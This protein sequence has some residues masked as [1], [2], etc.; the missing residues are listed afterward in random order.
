MK[1]RFKRIISLALS[2]S[3]MIGLCMPTYAA[4]ESNTLGVTFDVI[5]NNAMVLES[6]SDQTVI[7]TLKTNKGITVDG[8]GGNVIA[9]SPIIITDISTA[10]EKIPLD[11]TATNVENGKFGCILNG[12]DNAENVTEII[13]VTLTVPANTPAGSYNVGV[14]N[15]EL[16]ADFGTVWEKGATA[17]TTLTIEAASTPEPINGYTAGIKTINNP[18]TVDQPVN[19]V[20]NVGN[21]QSI[22]FA[23]GEIVV[24]YDSSKLTFNQAASTLGTAKVKDNAGTITLEDYG[25]FKN[26]GDIY[27]LSFTAVADGAAT[28]T[29]ES[30]KFIDK[31]NAVASDLIPATVLSPSEINVTIEKKTFDVT[32]PEGMESISGGSTVTDGEDFTFEIEDD[33]YDYSDIKATVDGVEVEVVKNDDGTYTVKG[34]KGKLAIT[35]NRTPKSY[36]VTFNG[37][38][39]EDITEKP[40]SATYKTDLTFTMPTAEGYSYSLDKITVG[41]TDYTG[42]TVAENVVTI[43]GADIIGEI[44]ITVGKTDTEAII[45]V[46]GTGAGAAAGYT[47]KAEMGKP[48][49]LTITPEAGYKYTVTATMN[50]ETVELIEDAENNT[51]TIEEVKGDIVFTVNQTVVVDGVEMN[52]Y[53]TVNGSKMWLIKNKVD[54]AEGKISTYDSQQMFWS[55]KY[56]AYCILVVADTLDMDT[57]N[58]NINISTGTAKAVAYDMDVNNTGVVDAADAQLVHNMYNAYYPGF[59]DDA[60]MEKFL[61]AD[62]NGDTVVNVEDATAII[63]YLLG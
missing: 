34:V 59:S 49:T 56:D 36:T 24:K 39:A 26:L 4:N 37:D 5:L 38:G 15:L 29:L 6:S 32:L 42:Y 19:I 9:D 63:N 27:T 52:E 58:A 13:V 53:L 14:Q 21:G 16:T 44:V 11:A 41:D 30:A 45:T 31:Q 25:E 8:I 7:M 33:N 18:A 12:T 51:Y 54:L 28:V 3:I 2:L 47:P 22:P 17:T 61:E 46:E 23:A 35:A 1:T 48:Y 57:V 50:G 10:D 55:E 43:P 60:T 62:T 20:V 40:T